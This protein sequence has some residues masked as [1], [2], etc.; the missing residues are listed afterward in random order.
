M[1]AGWLIPLWIATRPCPHTGSTAA[2]ET[3]TRPKTCGDADARNGIKITP[4]PLATHPKRLLST[5]AAPRHTP[6]TMKNMPPA[7]R[8]REQYVTRILEECDDTAVKEEL[9]IKDKGYKARVLAELRASGTLDNLRGQGRRPKYTD[10]Q[11]TA[12]QELLKGRMFFFSGGELVAALVEEGQ[13][14]AGIRSRG[15]MQ[16]LQRWSKTQKLHLAYGQRRLTFAMT[17][18]HAKGRLAW[19]H[20]CKSTLT[21]R[22][23]QEFWIEDEIT[24]NYGGHPKGECWIAGRIAPPC[25]HGAEGAAGPG[26]LHHLIG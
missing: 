14:E 21:K 4:A 9:G 19:C 5:A 3:C 1:K 24:I 2:D 11:F 23:L 7:K 20:S 25:L 22:K 10:E 16:A 12:A 6:T 8:R 26:L 13:L 15:F 17:A 18:E